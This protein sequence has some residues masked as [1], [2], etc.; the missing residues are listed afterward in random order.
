MVHKTVKTSRYKGVSNVCGSRW[1][2]RLAVNGKLYHRGPF[3]LQGQAV[4]ARR[5]MVQA[6][7]AGLEIPST[8]ELKELVK[9]V[10]ALGDEEYIPTMRERKR[11]ET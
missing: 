9:D 10:E 7:D 11:M 5:L 3:P 8:G 1:M 2:A 4:E 6:R